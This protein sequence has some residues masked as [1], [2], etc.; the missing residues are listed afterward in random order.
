MFHFIRFSPWLAGL[1][2]VAFVVG[3]NS[4]PAAP[5]N[6]TSAAQAPADPQTRITAAM[7]Q[8]A[9]EDR[10]LAEKQRMC[11]VSDEALG[12]MGAPIKLELK[13]QTVFI[14][15]ESCRE[16]AVN[17]PDKYLAKLGLS[18]EGGGNE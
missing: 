13:G 12:S 15:C 18:A 5:A 10:L 4:K 14:C 16:D 17:N 8:L 9:P 3:C 11:P 2:L 1:A 7:A 6:E